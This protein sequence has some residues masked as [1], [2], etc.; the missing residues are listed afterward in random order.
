MSVDTFIFFRDDRL[1][2]RDEWQAA[3]DAENAHITLDHVDNLREFS[4]YWPAKFDGHD[5]GFEWFY[6]PV[7]DMFGEQLE[8]AGDRHHAIDLVTHSDMR[9]LVCAMLAAGVLAKLI[10]GL[11][12]DEESGLL[13]TGDRAIEIA[14][15]IANSDL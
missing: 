10:D 1:P 12:L 5:S 9:E 3:L 7:A 8:G 6:G 14:R 2:S 11:F 13:V 15:Q 4:G